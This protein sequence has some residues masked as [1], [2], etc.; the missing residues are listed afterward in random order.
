MS[1]IIGGAGSKSG[2]IGTTEL[3]YEEGTFTPHVNGAGDYNP[4]GYT[5]SASGSYT[6][7][8]NMVHAQGN[9]NASDK[10]TNFG[11]TDCTEARHA[12]YS[13]RDVFVAHLG[14]QGMFSCAL[15]NFLIRTCRKYEDLSC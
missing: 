1:G 5:A 8:G 10:G 4:D 12:G 13:Q 7:I 14:Q 3:D 6:K 15:R 11:N 9:I 2:V